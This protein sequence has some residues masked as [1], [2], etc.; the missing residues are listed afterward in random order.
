[1]EKF[2][3][4]ERLPEF[5]GDI[6]RPKD[7]RRNTRTGTHG[8]NRFIRILAPCIKPAKNHL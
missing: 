4:E 7:R 5:S 2:D 8:A 1:M 6:I 3:L